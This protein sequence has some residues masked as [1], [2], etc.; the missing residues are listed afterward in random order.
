MHNNDI[1]QLAARYTPI[2]DDLGLFQGP[3]HHMVPVTDHAVMTGYQLGAGKVPVHYNP[4]A[5]LSA[6]G[7]ENRF[8]LSATT[9]HCDPGCVLIHPDPR[10]KTVKPLYTAHSYTGTAPTATTVTGMY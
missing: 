6:R 5:E 1:V 8:L 9:P 3:G 7:H 2:P 4:A 10:N